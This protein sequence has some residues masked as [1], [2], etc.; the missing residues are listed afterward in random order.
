MRQCSGRGACVEEVSVWRE[1][2]QPSTGP[3]VTAVHHDRWGEKDADL[4]KCKSA[5]VTSRLAHD[6]S[7]KR[8]GRVEHGMALGGRQRGLA[9]GGRLDSWSP[10]RFMKA[11]IQK[12][13]KKPVYVALGDYMIHLN[14]RSRESQQYHFDLT[15]PSFHY[16]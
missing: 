9:P 8:P 4:M 15:S 1:A 11:M 3:E 7:H 10:C 5:K 12:R 6:C 13:T 14:L 16:P 2:A